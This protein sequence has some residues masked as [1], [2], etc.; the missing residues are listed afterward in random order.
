MPP[1]GLPVG[2]TNAEL[3]QCFKMIA[4]GH[5]FCLIG[6][7]HGWLA[8]RRDEDEEEE[9]EEDGDGDGDG[10]GDGDGDGDGDTDS[11]MPSLCTGF[12]CL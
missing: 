12:Q 2:H 11:D 7:R 8:L 9:G 3:D 5:V 6:G 10:G 1:L 4:T